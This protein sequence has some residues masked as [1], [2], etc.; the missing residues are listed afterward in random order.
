MLK[1]VQ[2]LCRSFYGVTAVTAESYGC[3][4]YLK[5]RY[6]GDNVL[7]VSLESGV[8]VRCDNISQ[9]TLVKIRARHGMRNEQ[10]YNSLTQDARLSPTFSDPRL[11]GRP[12]TVPCH[13]PTPPYGGIA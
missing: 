13:P 12:K 3:V 1:T 8:E 4:W 6:A 7:E 9:R 11:R 2:E 5:Q 10:G